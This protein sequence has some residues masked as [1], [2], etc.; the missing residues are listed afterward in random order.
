MQNNDVARAILDYLGEL[1]VTQGRM[2]GQPFPVFAW[3]KRF[4]RGVFALGVVEG[5]LSI[6]RGN[7]KTTLVAGLA[8]AALD[9]PLAFP[10]SETIIA[11]SS[12]E[13]AR[14]AFGHVLAFLQQRHGASLEDKSLWRTWDSAN[15][16]WIQN[17]ANGCIVKAI[18][19]DPKPESTERGSRD[20]GAGDKGPG[21]ATVPVDFG[22]LASVNGL[23]WSC[24]AT[25]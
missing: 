17:R 15:K 18:G 8:A 7:G 22:S 3:E 14:M 12:F 1:T 2:A 13:Q 25:H 5:A 16:A 24:R 9:G 4:V 20:G 10:R 21:G 23:R 19:S 6:A 11:A